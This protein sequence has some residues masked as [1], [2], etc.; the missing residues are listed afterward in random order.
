MISTLPK[1]PQE[2]S[3]R[4]EIKIRGKRKYPLT[5]KSFVFEISVPSNSVTPHQQRGKKVIITHTHRRVHLF[6]SSFKHE[7][8]GTDSS[9]LSSD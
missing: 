3:V 7:K 6:L 1:T 5:Q 2:R 4:G 9:H 8:V